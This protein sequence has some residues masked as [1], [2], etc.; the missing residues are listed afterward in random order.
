VCMCV[1]MYV[2]TLCVDGYMKGWS[3]TRPICGW[4]GATKNRTFHSSGGRGGH[5]SMGEWSV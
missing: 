5:V 3:A 4:C 1:C 2:C